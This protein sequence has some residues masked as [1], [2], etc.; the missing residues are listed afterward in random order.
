MSESNIYNSIIKINRSAYA[1]ICLIAE[2]GEFLSA[3]AFLNFSSYWAWM[4]YPELRFDGLMSSR[5]DRR[6]QDKPILLAGY[7]IGFHREFV[8][9]NG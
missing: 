5:I 6:S 1:M 4:G 7:P 2:I 3:F 8:K 9:L